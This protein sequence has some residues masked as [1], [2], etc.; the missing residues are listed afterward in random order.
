M[1]RALRLMVV[2]LL[3]VFTAG[4]WAAGPA[5]AAPSIEVSKTT[6]LDPKGES[7]QV[8][9]AGFTPGIDIYLVVCDPAVP[10]GGACDLGNYRQVTIT[11]DGSFSSDMKPVAKF[12]VANCIKVGCAI[13]T[14][15]VG[16]GKDRTQETL[17]PI[18][19]KGQTAPMVTATA[20]APAPS[21]SA[22]AAGSES[23]APA[24]SNTP[25]SD[26]S[27]VATA[28]DASSSSSTLWI[29]LGIAAVVVIGIVVALSRRKPS[30]S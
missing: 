28:D 22:T 2:A 30:N 1:T 23:A 18:G 4:L 20:G 24:D 25:A 8:T 13:Q 11:A 7:I 19:F 16:N 12:S 6:N 5:S 27:N 9:G 15:H 21:G 14:S 29:V 17:V 10:N 3:A 26:A